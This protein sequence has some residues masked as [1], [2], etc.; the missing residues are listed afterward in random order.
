MTVQDI[1]KIALQLNPKERARLAGLL[2]E[3]LE[4]EPDPEIE[5]IWADEAERRLRVAENDPKAYRTAEE[6][7]KDAKLK[8]GK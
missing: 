8:L 6:V 4:S 2:L 5:R 3:S 1:E 7:L